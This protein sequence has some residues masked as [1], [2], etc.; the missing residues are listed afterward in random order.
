MG[1]SG[2]IQ[3]KGIHLLTMHAAKGLEYD[4]VFLMDVN[5]GNV[6][7]LRKGENVTEA[8]LEE[9]RR[10]FYVGMTRARDSLELLY[11]TGTKER[12]RLLSTFLRPLLDRQ[13]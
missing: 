12:P 1:G 10:L 9:E 7:K 5:E 3:K 6:P 8:L 2:A 4:R 13:T 11:Q